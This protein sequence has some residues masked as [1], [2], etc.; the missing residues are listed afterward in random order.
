M[1][2]HSN[3]H[4]GIDLLYFFMIV[5]GSLLL[6]MI[7]GLAA[8]VPIFGDSIETIQLRLSSQNYQ[9]NL[10]LLRYFQIINQIGL[11]L[12]PTLMFGWLIRKPLKNFYHLN[13]PLNMRAAVIGSL[14]IF[15]ILPFI[16][17]LTE[18]NMQLSLP[19]GLSNLQRWME[20]QEASANA[21]TENFL[22]GG[23]IGDFSVNLLMIAVLPAIGEELFFR[24]VLQRL[25]HEWIQ[26][27][28][29]AIVL[30]SLLF[31]ALHLQFFGFLPRFLLGMLFG[32]FYY[33]SGSLW[34]PIL[35]HFVNNG[36]AVVVAWLSANNIIKTSYKEFGN[37]EMN[38]VTLIFYTAISGIL[39]FFL[40]QSTK[41]AI[42]NES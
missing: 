35:T 39:I 4:P 41:N 27:I 32:Y 42:R 12:I 29:V 34:L 22:S 26:N 23:T 31:S 11:F 24:G 30:T 36:M 6:T 20:A 8:A 40:W 17:L 21:L 18:W 14:L 15:T 1:R 13:T 10:S 9:A 28:H 38:T 2:I 3:R 7:V 33:W 37:Y 19:E 5:L 25:F 16:N